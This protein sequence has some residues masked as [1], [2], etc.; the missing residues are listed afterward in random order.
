M[1]VSL[2]ILKKDLKQAFVTPF[3]AVILISFFVLSLFFFFS[4]LTTYNQGLEK[5]LMLG[6]GETSFYALVLEPY[7]QTVE[8]IFL[9]VIP[10]IS[11][12]TIAHERESHTL[13]LLLSSAAKTREIVVAKCAYLFFLVFVVLSLSFIFPL[14]FYF[15]FDLE[16]LPILISFLGLLLFAFSFSV[17]GLLISSVCKTQSI[18]SV[19]MV[20]LMLI[21]F[22]IDIPGNSISGM[23]SDVLLF[24]S[25][26]EHLEMFFKG[27]L[28]GRDVF[29]FISVLIVAL[30]FSMRNLDK[31]RISE[32]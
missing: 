17:L 21:L 26:G 2:S 7:Y 25:P 14:Y 18:S 13:S 29:Y 27:V 1:S 15:L 11:M 23:F 22:S 5:S 30:F 8:I 20:F 4:L 9:F 28:R 24:L 19:V 3:V 10:L 6:F 31:S 12:G 16:F 32:C